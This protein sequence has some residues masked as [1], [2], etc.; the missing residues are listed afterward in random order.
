LS[1]SQP[2]DSTDRLAHPSASLGILSFSKGQGTRHDADTTSEE[3]AAR[4]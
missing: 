2:F 4:L 1:L 3:P